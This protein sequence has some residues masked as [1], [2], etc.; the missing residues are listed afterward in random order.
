[1]FAPKV[2]EAYAEN[3]WR[4]GITWIYGQTGNDVVSI[5]QP[6]GLRVYCVKPGEPFQAYGKAAEDF[7]K[8]H[9][10]LG[11]IGYD[12]KPQSGLFCPSWLLSPA[13][14][15]MRRVLEDQLVG[16][17]DAERCSA[18]SWDIEQ[19][20]CSEKEGFCLCPRCLAAFRTQQGL[21]GDVKL[22]AESIAKKHKDAWVMFRCR[23]NAELVGHVRGGAEAMRPA[24]RILRL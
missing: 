19:P 17:V 5:L 4:S 11:A 16:T 3:A 12:G 8:A 21:A 24:H 6:R 9:P 23:Q 22:D 2:A 13:G 15:K 20:V 7:L 10:E 1:M 14:V 18:L